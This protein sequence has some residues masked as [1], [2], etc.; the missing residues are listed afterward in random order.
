MRAEMRP[1][2]PHSRLRDRCP[3]AWARLAV[4]PVD[5]KLV[6]HAAAVAV[7]A[8]VVPQRRALTG[9]AETQRLLDTPAQP[10]Q[11][12]R[13]ETTRRPKRIEARVP[14]RLVDVDVSEARQR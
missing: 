9:D 10:A 1:A 12:V 7:W 8:A 6:L 5:A 2:A 4:T 11:L 3:A 13:V 14:E